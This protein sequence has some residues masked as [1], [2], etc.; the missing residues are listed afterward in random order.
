MFTRVL[1]HEPDKKESF[2]K[3]D[4]FHTVNMGVGKTFAASSL[5]ILLKHC[6]GNSVEER[7]AQL[8]VHRVLPRL[9]ARKILK[10]F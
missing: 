2:H 1:M 4:L 10:H 6:P 9:L 8:L 7:L 5:V 3:V